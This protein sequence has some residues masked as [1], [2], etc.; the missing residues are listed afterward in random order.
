MYFRVFSDV[1]QTTAMMAYILESYI[2]CLIKMG[3]LKWKM[4]CAD[5][6]VHDIFVLGNDT[7]M[8]Y[9]RRERKSER[10]FYD[11]YHQQSWQTVN[12]I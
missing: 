9:V 11:S 6:H 12:I 8:Y 1:S 2:K 3:T 10:G 7:Y 5:L 4:N